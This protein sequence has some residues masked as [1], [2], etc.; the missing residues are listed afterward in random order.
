MHELIGNVVQILD[1]YRIIINVGEGDLHFG[2]HVEVIKVGKDVIDSEGNNLGPFITVKAHLDVIQV[3]NKYSICE[4]RI[5]KTVKRSKI[6][7]LAI[8]PLLRDTVVIE[9]IP[10]N[11]DTND[12]NHTD[13]TNDD[14]LIR[15]GDSVRKA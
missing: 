7:E 5:T 6:S 1:E 4:N 8:S 10:L 13:E 3:E 9:R 12:I 15:I 14:L 11:I 2:D